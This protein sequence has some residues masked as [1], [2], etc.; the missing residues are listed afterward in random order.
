MGRYRKSMKDSLREA[1]LYGIEETTSYPPK[2][3][4][5]KKHDAY[6]DPK[7]GE[8]E[9]IKREEEDPSVT[10]ISKGL[11]IDKKTVKKVMGEK[12]DAL[13]S[14][15]PNDQQIR[16]LKTVMEPMR[17]G[18]ISPENGLKLIKMMDKFK[19]KEDL[20]DLFKA[21]IPFVSALAAGR[22]IQNHG[23]SG[24]D[25]NKLKE[26]LEEGYTDARTKA[27]REH[28]KKLESA[29]QRREEKKAKLEKEGKM[30]QIASYIDDIVHAMKKDRNMKP[31]IDRFKKDAEK[32]L[33]PKKSLEK[34]LPDYIPGKD[35]AKI[36]NMS[37]DFEEARLGYGKD[38]K[39]NPA[40]LKGSDSIRIQ[41]TSGM[42][43]TKQVEREI[44]LQNKQKRLGLNLRRQQNGFIV[45][46][47]KDSIVQLLKGLEDKFMMGIVNPNSLP[48]TVHKEEVE[49]D[50]QYK[51][52]LVD[53]NNKVINIFGD[54]NSANNFKKNNE[55]I[56]KKEL[57]P[58]RIQPMRPNEYKMGD[59]VLG[60]GEETL[61]ENKY[62]YTVV[63]AKKGKEIVKANS[64]YEAA[65]KFAQMKGLK[66]TAGVDAHLMEET[67]NE[68]T[69]KDFDKNEDE[70][71]HTE[72]G[73]AIVNKFGTS[74]EKMQMA[75]IA[76]RHKMNNSISIQDQ[77]ARDKMINKY[78]NKLES[79]NLDEKSHYT[80]AQIK[81]AYG[82]AND[83][84]YKQGNMQGAI[85][86]IEKIAKGLSK[87]PD[88][89]KVLRRTQEQLE[90]GLPNSA[91]RNALIKLAKQGGMDKRDYEKAEIMYRRGEVKDLRKMIYDLDTEPRE[92]IMSVISK[93]DKAFFK[94]MYPKARAGD[95]MSSIS[96]QH[97]NEDYR[98]Q[99][100]RELVE[101]IAGL[102]KKAEKSGMPYGILKKVFDRG[103]AAWKGGHRPGA[104]QHQWAFARVNSFITKSS[105]TWGGA[106]KDL[107]AK[108]R[109]KSK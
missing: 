26:E 30:S 23:M 38:V 24:R 69:K 70:N 3:I 100:A 55:K 97:R 36:L 85:K 6:K 13:I 98:H 93:N 88:V 42:T 66:S 81:Q 11:K 37:E 53:K 60:I 27:Y 22:L 76:S 92:E 104:S 12:L 5:K 48:Y 20:V 63:H 2:A 57:K 29:R 1:R 99:G 56:I 44:P 102:Q 106:D 73:V 54:K 86:T 33:D 35:I 15:G 8:H 75:G 96:Y 79:V 68:F 34:I 41:A 77:Q 62:T 89:Q 40:S 45:K 18:K 78:Y 9:P 107:A 103:M 31:F 72:N 71:K 101:K 19:K 109:E 46:G 50:E 83:P 59:T 43:T 67:I 47:R 80:S 4:N 21:D 94:K 58:L 61:D 84:R 39:I 17:G 25:V 82:I 32:T 49:L 7:R 10:D 51:Y 108:V 28:R 64:S 95:Y 14:E 90:E 87:H 52:A 105:G 91:T 74:A 16:T 65:K